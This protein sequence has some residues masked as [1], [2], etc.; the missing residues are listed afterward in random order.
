MSHL[1]RHVRATAAVAIAATGGVVLAATAAS[2]YPSNAFT[3]PSSSASP[4]VVPV[5]ASSQVQSLITA[6]DK[7][8]KAGAAAGTTWQFNGTPDGIGAFD[9]GDG[10]YTALVNH[11]FGGTAGVARAHGSAGAY[12]SRLVIRKAD[13]RVLSGED[14]IKQAFLGNPLTATTPAAAGAAAFSRFCSA[15]LPAVSAFFHA[16][17]GKG[18]QARIFMNG[19]ESGAEGRGVGHVATGPDTGKSYELPAI[20]R[21]SWE[22]SVANPGTG[23]K[24]VVAGTDD[25]SAPGGEVYVYIGDKKAGGSTEVEKAGLTGGSLYG[26]AVQVPGGS[27]TVALEDR[28]NALAP[29]S[30]TA[31]A[32]TGSF[33]L[34][35]TGD[36]TGKTGAQLQTASDN[37]VTKFLRPEDFAWDADNPAVGYFQ[38]TDRFDSVKDGTGSQVGRSRLWRLAFTDVNNLP[39]GGTITALLD[40]TEAINML[41]N[42]STSKGGKLI[43]LEDVGNQPHNGKAWQYDVATDALKLLLQHDPDRFGD[44]N[45]AATAPFTQDEEASGVVD[46][47]DLYGAPAGSG[48]YFLFDDQA[49]YPIS[50]ETVEGGQLMLLHLGAAVPPQFVG[51]PGAVVAE[52]PFAVGLPVLAIVVAGGAYLLKRRRDG[53]L[54]LA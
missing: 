13:N 37:N 16:A 41:D 22:N 50:G 54:E 1:H 14:L 34:F 52:V 9:N 40:G 3:G 32:Y 18:T 20:G 19:E 21:F 7:V 47:S 25:N 2:A 29:M 10:T 23:D 27:G 39:A 44:L 15:D 46:V 8:A 33:T 48:E 12:V 11:E 24:T 35:N 6:T 28:A 17:T 4:Y 51:S 53:R 36:A 5:D 43:L 30:A 38:T 45:R 49:H 42:F 26:V 31:P